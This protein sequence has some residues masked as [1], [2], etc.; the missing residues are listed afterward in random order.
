M[1]LLIGVVNQKSMIMRKYE[2]FITDKENSNTAFEV[3]Q[4]ILE[5]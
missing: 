1:I 5:Q 3:S 2:F 4:N